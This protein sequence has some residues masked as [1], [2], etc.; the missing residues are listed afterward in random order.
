MSHTCMNNSFLCLLHVLHST[1]HCLPP[2]LTSPH[3]TLSPVWSSSK[4][5]TG[6]FSF[7]FFVT[8][9]FLLLVRG[10]TRSCK[11]TATA[12]LRFHAH[13]ETARADFVSCF[14]LVLFRANQLHSVHPCT[15][16]AWLC[17]IECL[18]LCLGRPVL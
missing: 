2:H 15:L 7:Y 16:F 4:N 1:A 18:T 3:L 17:A 13:L 11:S 12:Q 14:F 9:P 5:K 8:A 10:A 6:N